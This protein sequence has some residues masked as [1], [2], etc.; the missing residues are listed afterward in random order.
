MTELSEADREALQ[1]SLDRVLLEEPERRAQIQDMLTGEGFGRGWLSTALFCS[2]RL[3]RRALGARPWCAVPADYRPGG[4]HGE[5]PQ[6]R[7]AREKLMR[8]MAAAGVSLYV[9]DPIAALA[10]VSA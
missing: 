9:A 10:K 8:D 7:S 2:V 3:Q 5:S 1:A 4:W 6:V